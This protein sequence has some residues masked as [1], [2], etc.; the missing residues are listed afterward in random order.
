MK[1]RTV[2][3]AVIEEA[4]A[5]TLEDSINTWLL[6]TQPEADLK[7]IDLRVDGGVYTALILYV[8]P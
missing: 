2:H 3:V 4:D 8:K 5:A 1:A 7:S 6:D